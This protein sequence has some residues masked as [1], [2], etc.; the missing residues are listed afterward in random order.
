MTHEWAKN[1]FFIS[2]FS[3][4]FIQEMLSFYSSL[5]LYHSSLISH[6]LFCWSIFIHG[7]EE[8]LNFQ[9]LVCQKIVFL[10]H[11]IG[12]I[13]YKVRILYPKLFPLRNPSFP[14]SEMLLMLL[15]K[16]LITGCFSSLCRWPSYSSLWKIPGYF[17][18]SL[19]K[20]QNNVKGIYVL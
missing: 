18:S 19:L 20:M 9:A 2:L 12:F 13:L 17:I 7:N 3:L 1:A 11:L 10:I 4:Y 5:S 15:G 6:I 8:V 14:S 16:C